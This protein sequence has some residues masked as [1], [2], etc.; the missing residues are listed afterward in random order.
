M[1]F[2]RVDLQNK[3]VLLLKIANKNSVKFLLPLLLMIL[4]TLTMKERCNRSQPLLP[5]LTVAWSKLKK[6]IKGLPD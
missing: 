1:Y 6:K 4:T 3:I 2:S 5:F